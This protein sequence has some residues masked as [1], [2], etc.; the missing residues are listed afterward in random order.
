MVLPNTSQPKYTTEGPAI[1]RAHLVL[2][3]V[4]EEIASCN[5]DL[6]VGKTENGKGRV[7]LVPNREYTPATEVEAHSI[8][9]S[10]RNVRS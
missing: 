10:R 4:V 9:H 2:S 3:K 5:S 1:Q 8:T 6:R 7:L